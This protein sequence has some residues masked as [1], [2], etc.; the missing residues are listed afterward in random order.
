MGICANAFKS[1][2]FSRLGKFWQ[3]VE[4]LKWRRI[5]IEMPLFRTFQRRTNSGNK[6]INV[7]FY[8]LQR[9]GGG[10]YDSR[11]KSVNKKL[12][13]HS[14]RISEKR[15][16]PVFKGKNLDANSGGRG[17]TIRKCITESPSHLREM[18]FAALFVFWVS[19]RKCSSVRLDDR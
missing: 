1:E 18:T 12:R 7:V 5:F 17:Q 16:S 8:A 14:S 9:F 15:M 19:K 2:E 4:T 3:H 13:T 11:W 10:T 6:L